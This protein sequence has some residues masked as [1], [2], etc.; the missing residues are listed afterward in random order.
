MSVS[1]QAPSTTHKRLENLRSALRAQALD[2]FVL[3]RADEHQGEY[4]PACA[5]R[6]AWLTGFTGSAGAAVVLQ[7]KAAIFVDGRYTLQVR[8]QVD[9]ELF[10]PHHL[11]LEPPSSWLGEHATPGLRIGFDPWLHTPDQV[12]RLREGTELAGAELVAVSLNPVDQVWDDR[13]ASPSS[14]VT[15]H[16]LELAGQPAESKRHSLAST[17]QRDRFDASVLSA[18]DS[19]AWLLNIR[20]GDVERTP[21][22]LSFAILYADG[23]VDWFIKGAKVSAQVREALGAEVRLH[24]P[25]AFIST[26]DALSGKRVLLDSSTAGFAI[27]ERLVAAGAKAVSGADP[28]ALPKACKNPVEIEGS[29]QAHLRDAVAMC[30]FLA[31]LST[32]SGDGSLRE[33]AASDR[34]EQLR[35]Q[36][37]S[38]RDLS[39]DSISGAG[40]NGAIVHYKATPDTERPLLAGEVYLIDSGAQYPEGTTDITRTVAIGDVGAEARERHTLVLRGHIALARAVFPA[41]TSGMQLDALARRPL[42]EAGLDYD[43]GTGHGVGAYLSVHE[44]PQRIAKQ[45]SSV[46]LQP[47]MI[48]SN[49][50]G[51]YK[52]GAYGIRIENLVAV[53]PVEVPGAEHPMLGFETLTLVPIDRPMIAAERLDAGER[54]WLNAYHA[55]VRAK[56]RPLLDDVTAAWLDQATAP[57]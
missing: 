28:C 30:R 4:V 36:D 16:P 43:H 55:T 48:C 22:A 31:W 39:F 27:R 37:P 51:Y 40:S 2:G 34:L 46:A 41:G 26:L 3:P 42:W 13:P 9:T 23:T 8:A 6:L 18:P 25:T 7:D 17:L 1:T 19:I 53:E 56:V 50:P 45:G 57:I 10:A 52:T 11:I 20:G 24:E 15:L 21:I 29:R 32:Y 33:I 14:P 49:E 5:A 38:C 44:G 35:R 54:A 12:A 47:G